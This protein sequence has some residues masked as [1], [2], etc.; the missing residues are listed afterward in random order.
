MFQAKCWKG[1]PTEVACLE[2]FLI[3]KI[4]RT[5]KLKIENTGNQFSLDLT[6]QK[7]LGKIFLAILLQTALPL[8]RWD[9]GEQCD[10]IAILIFMF[11]HSQQWKFAQFF[12]SR[13]EFSKNYTNF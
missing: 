3:W 7:F 12:K 13:F 2:L 1:A 11:V 5:L 4:D 9:S 6:N 10:R 8:G